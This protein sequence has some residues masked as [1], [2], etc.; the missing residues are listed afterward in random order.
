VTGGTGDIKPQWMV[1]NS[2]VITTAQYTSNKFPLPSNRFGNT[3]GSSVIV[4]ILKAQWFGQMANLADTAETVVGIISTSQLRTTTDACTL[5]T[6]ED[7]FSNANVLDGVVR[8][9]V[10]TT[11]GQKSTVLPIVHDLTDN[12]GNGILVATD[13]IFLTTGGLSIANVGVMT[14]RLLYRFVKVTLAEYIGI[15]QGQSSSG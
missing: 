6:I 1:L 11:S 3:K 7:D 12:N 8:N 2:S 9:E 4:E 15:V 13:N 10:V 5:A 14:V